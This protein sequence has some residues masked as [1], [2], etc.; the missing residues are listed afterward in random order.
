ML[1]E[2]ISQYASTNWLNT[3]SLYPIQ[4]CTDD[5]VTVTDDASVLYQ[6]L[7]SAVITT[8]PFWKS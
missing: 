1:V 7:C 8:S 3:V 6:I 5:K 2:L 4:Q